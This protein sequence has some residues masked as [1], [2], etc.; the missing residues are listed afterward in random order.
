[1]IKVSVLSHKVIPGLPGLCSTIFICIYSDIKKKEEVNSAML[2]TSMSEHEESNKVNEE[3]EHSR[4][5]DD[6]NQP[7]LKRMI[8][9]SDL[10]DIKPRSTQV[11]NCDEV[12]FDPNGIW[13]KVICAYKSFKD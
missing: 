12:G 8:I 5:N 13:D 9:P 1:M 11:W 2:L 7:I 3:L 10:N 6:N 4:D